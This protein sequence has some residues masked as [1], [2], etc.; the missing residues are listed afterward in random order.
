M[1]QESGPESGVR[2]Q[3]VADMAAAAGAGAPVAA[4][5]ADGATVLWASAAG[6]ALLGLPPQSTLPAALDPSRLPVAR[7]AELAAGLAPVAGQRLERLRLPVGRRLDLVTLACRRVVGG[8]GPDFLMLAGTPPRGAAPQPVPELTALLAVAPGPQTDAVLTAEALVARAGGRPFLRFIW[9]C[10]GSGRITAL[11]PDLGSAIGAA[12]PADA[13]TWPAF[14]ARALVDSEGRVG[15]AVAAGRTFTGLDVTWRLAS[16]GHAVPVSLSGVPTVVDRVVTGFRGFGLVRLAGLVVLDAG[17]ALDAHSEP[18]PVQTEVPQP[19]EGPAADE[20]APVEAS[21]E[22]SSSAPSDDEV[23]D[24]AEEGALPPPATSVV[25]FPPRT[26]PEPVDPKVVPLRGAPQR[27][28]VPDAGRGLSRSERH[29]FREIARA[30]GARIEGED[31]GDDAVVE[32]AAAAEAETAAPEPSAGR[33]SSSSPAEAA[34]ATGSAGAPALTPAAEAALRAAAAAEAAA[35]EAVRAGAPDDGAMAGAAGG[36]EATVDRG[37]AADETPAPAAVAEVSAPVLPVPVVAAAPEAPALSDLARHAE[38]LFDRLPIGVLVC[39]GEVPIVMNRTLRDLVGWDSIDAFY[40]GGG[41]ARMFRGRGAEAIPAG[42]EGGTVALTTRDGD[43]VAVDARIQTLSWD[44]LPATLMSFRRAADVDLTPRLKAAELELRRR[45]SEEREL[46]AILDTATDGVIVLDVDGRILSINRS[47]EALFGYDQKEI[48]GETFISLLAP[49]S[50]ATALDYLEGL[51]SNGVASVLNDGREVVGRVRQGGRIPLFMTLGAIST[52][53]EV[54]FCA[55]LRDI[56]PWKKAEADLMEAK[57][58]AEAASSQKSDFLAKIS[59]EIRTPL[60][61]IIGFAEVMIEERFG[62]VGNERYLEYL[63]DIHSSGGHVISLVND[64]LDLSK[65]EAGRFDLTF[66]GVDVNE[67]VS[68]SVSLMQPQAGASRV[69]VRTALSA[70]L[71]RVVADE[72]SLRQ[73]VLNL[74]SNAVKFTDPGG[75][76]IV[77]TA[78][79]D[80]GEVAIRVR[81]TGI[82]MTDK[83]IETALEPFRQLATARRAGGTGLGLPLT[84]ALV[85]ANRATMTIRSARDSGTLVEVL[86][87]TNRVLAE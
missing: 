5:A 10:D 31:E 63:R 44:G 59:H 24:L 2:R 17:I 49:D 65:I 41:L 37:L 87:P 61:A 48:A 83:E 19:A 76:V 54:R 50:H 25:P 47:G 73:I 78:F 15:A 69:V 9:Q 40:D 28:P 46:R 33:P 22:S 1:A 4:L 67:I 6:L 62:P 84:K 64:L 39:R 52:A 75:Q 86:F 42:G 23:I 51:K 16:G 38:E 58:A 7:F 85:E 18:P 60:S 27:P 79:T 82:G 80:R 32:P 20:P 14:E 74:L 68:R 81:D 21:A 13:E 71:P 43:I 34:A 45:E 26:P 72:R 77:S 57:K 56:T 55:V 66:V 30:L 35:A 8:G 70:R 3:V 53:P 36:T 29:A 11:S 12:M